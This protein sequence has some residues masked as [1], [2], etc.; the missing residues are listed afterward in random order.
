MAM[1]WI[2]AISLLGATSQFTHALTCYTCSSPPTPECGEHFEGTS[3]PTVTCSSV[4]PSCVTV[5]T[6]VPVDGML[7][8]I[9]FITAEAKLR[10]QYRNAVVFFIH[11]FLYL[12]LRFSAHSTA[13]IYER[14]LQATF[15]D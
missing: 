1:L 2:V 11:L 10:R 8:L 14:H 12:F 3:V 7:T 6:K 4:Q 9:T 13:V 15:R 5:T